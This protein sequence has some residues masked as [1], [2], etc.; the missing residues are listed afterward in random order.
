MRIALIHI[1][2]ISAAPMLAAFERHW[3]EAEV[4]N[5]LD[6]DLFLSRERGHDHV[7]E[8]FLSVASYAVRAPANG[9]LFTCSAFGRAIEATQRML[10]PVPVLKPNEAMIE[11]AVARGR[12][13]GLLATFAPTLDTMPEEFPR[14]TLAAKVFVPGAFKA[15]NEGDTGR[16]D[17]LIAEAAQRDLGGCDV[18]A[19][20]QSSMA[21]SASAVAAATG[22]PVLTSPDTAVKKLRR[23]LEPATV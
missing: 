3:P 5:V 21:S 15:L 4:F 10:A 23:L 17:R 6:E 13:I 14:G 16:H 9:I 2:M 20:A 7:S 18:I 11:A 8:R 19:L 22:K 1:Q 12:R